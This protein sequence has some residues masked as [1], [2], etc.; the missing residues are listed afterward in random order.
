M[1]NIQH[2]KHPTKD[3]NNQTNLNP[4]AAYGICLLISTIFFF[5]F[6][7]NS[8]IYTFN[9]D[10][11]YHWFLTVGHGMVAGKLPYRDMFEHKGPIVYFVMAF[12][13]LFPNPNF[14]M[15]LIE[16]V[17]MSLFFYFTYRIANKRLNTFYSLLAVIIMTLT[18]FTSWC[19]TRSAATVEEFALPIY[20]YFLLC[21]LEFLLEKREWNWK[22]TLCLG[23]CFGIMF[24]VK[25]TLL[26]FVIVP[27][28]IWF[29]QSL[30]N[31]AYRTTVTNILFILLGIIIVTVPIVIY[32]TSNHIL[33]DL[34]HVYF[35]INLTAYGTTKLLTVLISFSI[36]FLI[37]PMVLF[38]IIWGVVRFSITHWRENSG[39]LLLT[40]FLITLALLIWSSKNITYYYSA[41]IPYSI[42]GI[43]DILDL[44]SQKLTLPHWHKRLYAII[45]ITCILACIPLSV[46]TYEWGRNRKSY[47]PLAIADEIH[48]YEV[49]NNTTATMFCYHIGDFGF[50]NAAGIVPNNYYF[51]N[52]VFDQNRF[53]E[54]Y[55]AFNDYIT[56]QTSDFVI[57]ERKTW[58][59]EYDFL[60]QYYQP[61]H[62]NIEDST[63][64]Y[65]KMHYF[66][67]R[68]FDFV[69]LIKKA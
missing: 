45:V 56:N 40:A 32:F 15:L 5:L 60:A 49:N 47:A 61:Y 24:W 29:I 27:M 63:Y 69:L 68:E 46:Y 44:V 28:L 38:F 13:C 52:N 51:A 30:R 21:W 58:D 34:F 62:G 22:R 8:P 17:S 1:K 7:F 23:L 33:H 31:K 65:H 14:I 54:M 59:N 41:L 2:D 55:Q 67:Y 53:P 39:R 4:W 26:Y 10:N 43:I 18:I 25:Y 66:Y 50:Y 20:A 6:G 12:C 64:H 48:N 37:G 9:S 57:T 42:L 16:I 3:Y 36:F 19:R 11:D 35:I